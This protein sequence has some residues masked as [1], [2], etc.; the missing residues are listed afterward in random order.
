[1]LIVVF[2]VE[3]RNELD[4]IN[5]VRSFGFYNIVS[6]IFVYAS[7]DRGHD[8]DRQY[9][10]EQT[11]LLI[12]GTIPA[13]RIVGKTVRHI[14]PNTLYSNGD[15]HEMEIRGIRTC[16]CGATTHS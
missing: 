11:A 14:F 10:T 15:G 4:S 8:H 3:N 1:M 7:L 6:R 12:L 9:L 16:A 5:W 13:S 2:G